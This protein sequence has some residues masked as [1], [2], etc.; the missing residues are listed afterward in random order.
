MAIPFSRFTHSP[1]AR[2][3][4]RL[5]FGPMLLLLLLF[6]DIALVA[7]ITATMTYSWTTTKYGLNIGFYWPRSAAGRAYVLSPSSLL[8][9]TP[10]PHKTHAATCQRDEKWK[11]EKICSQQF[12]ERILLYLAVPLIDLL[13]HLPA[14]IAAYLSTP[15]RRQAAAAASSSSFSRLHPVFALCASIFLFGAWVWQV[16]TTCV[17]DFVGWENPRDGV[18]DALAA[19]RAAVGTQIALLWAAYLGWSAAAV[20]AWRRERRRVGEERAREEGRR[21]G[22][23]EG[24]R[25]A[26]G[27]GVELRGLEVDGKV[28]GETGNRGRKG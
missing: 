12:S 18:W 23:E 20:H 21:Q 10:L 28:N 1:P 19:V 24:R 7:L 6:L 9:C 5:R 8:H 27:M 14:H 2:W 13:L 15:R 11:K 26:E 22:W 17:M 25:E 16:T 4:G 3:R